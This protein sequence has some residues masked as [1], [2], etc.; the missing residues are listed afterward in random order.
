M[1]SLLSDLRH[2]WRAALQTPVLSAIAVVTIA[3]GIGANS[4]IFSLLQGSVSHSAFQNPGSLIFLFKRFASV[5][6]GPGSVPDFM[7]WRLWHRF[8]WN[9]SVLP[10]PAPP[11]P[12]TA[13]RGELRDRLYRKIISR[14]SGFRQTSAI[15]N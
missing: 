12:D 11:S 8:Q 9:D 5:D 6:E 14:C 4:V 10:Q 15:R 2:A 3:L 1:K 13:S 7:E